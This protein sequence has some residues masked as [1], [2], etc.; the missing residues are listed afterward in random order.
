MLKA[1]ISEV[2]IFGESVIKKDGSG[3]VSYSEVSNYSLYENNQFQIAAVASHITHKSPPFQ[4]YFILQ[5]L[6]LRLRLIQRPE[7]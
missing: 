1:D 7:L 4:S 3:K 2:E 5:R 6:L